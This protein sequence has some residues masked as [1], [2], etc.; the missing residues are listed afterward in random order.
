MVMIEAR[1]RLIARAENIPT[2]EYVTAPD[3]LAA[4]AAFKQRSG[5]EDRF[6]HSYVVDR[7]IF[8]GGGIGLK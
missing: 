8:V 2:G 5:K 3:K 1:E 4:H 7:P 6:A